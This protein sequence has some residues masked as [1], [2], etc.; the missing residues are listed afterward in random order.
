VVNPSS[1]TSGTEASEIRFPN[2]LSSCNNFRP[3]A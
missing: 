1:A 3:N 2:L